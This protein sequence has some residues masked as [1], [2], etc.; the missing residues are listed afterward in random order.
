MS[1]SK[2]TNAIAGDA[3]ILARRYARALYEL[4]EEKKQ[5]D[6]VAA[7]LGSLQV[8]LKVSAEFREVTSNPRLTRAQAVESMK[9]V[10]SLAK[11]NPLTQNFLTLLAHNSRLNLLE[12]AIKV[13]LADLTA[14]RGEFIAEVT[15][16]KALASEQQEQ[17]SKQLDK[18]AGGK[19]HLV[20]KEDASLLGGLVVK[21]GSRLIDASVKGKLARL[22]RQ[23]KSQQEAA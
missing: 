9:K 7:D 23:L 5:L 10:A 4:A 13:F 16:P 20:I 15:T 11:L 18:I 17:L 3:A 6:S 12:N 8:L 21:L 1:E 14:R 2:N 22:E 19:V